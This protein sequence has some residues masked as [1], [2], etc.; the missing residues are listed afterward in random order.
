MTKR[1]LYRSVPLVFWYQCACDSLNQ[2]GLKE[3]PRHQTSTSEGKCY[4]CQYPVKQR[5]T[6]KEYTTWT[7]V[8][9]MPAFIH[10]H[11]LETC[12][13]RRHAC[14]LKKVSLIVT[15]TKDE[16]QWTCM[17]KTVNTTLCHVRFLF[18]FMPN[19]KCCV[20]NHWGVVIQWTHKSGWLKMTGSAVIWSSLQFGSFVL[21][22]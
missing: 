20:L 7:K 6:P 9:V 11:L 12:Y 4:H 16:M 10:K 22:E 17:N 5:A 1:C 18:F 3:M 15:Q 19:V 14:Y 2:D 8:C 21:Q 13:H